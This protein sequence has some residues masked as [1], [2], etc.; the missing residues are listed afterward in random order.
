MPSSILLNEESKTGGTKENDDGNVKPPMRPR[1]QIDDTSTGERRAEPKLAY[2]G[3]RQKVNGGDV[4]DRVHSLERE[5]LKLK[6]K[7]NLL[8]NEIRK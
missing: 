3:G 2:G 8:E 4:E 6:A 5:N 7:E 1:V